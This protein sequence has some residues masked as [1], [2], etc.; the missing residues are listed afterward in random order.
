MN[1]PTRC[2]VL[3]VGGGAAGCIIA[4]RI[5]E[6]TDLRVLLVEAGRS[7][8]GDAAATDLSR[9]DEQDESYDWGF[10]AQTMAGKSTAIDYARAKML[11]G[12][13]NHND[14]AF[15]E[16]TPNDLTQWVVAGAAGWDHGA[17]APYLA[18]VR[19][20]VGIEAAPAG[21]ALSRALIDAA[22]VLGLEERNFRDAIDAGAGWFPLNA[23]GS[24]RQSSSICYLHPLSA[25]PDNLDV[26]TDTTVSALIMEGACV[27]GARTSRGDVAAARE[28]VLTAGSIGSP[29]LMMVSGIGPAD[30][31]LAHGVPVHAALAGVGQNLMDHVAANI[32]YE[33]HEAPAPWDRTPCEATVLMRT[34]P[35]AVDPDVLFHFVLRLREK[36][37]GADQFAGVRHGVKLS[38]NVARP[39]SRGTLTLA[40]PDIAVQPAL[41][42]NYLSDPDGYDRRTLLRGLRFARK[43]AAAEPLASY[44]K[45]EVSPG[46]SIDDDDA[47]FAYVAETCETV[48]HPS[49]TCRMGR[50]DDP[51]AVVTP[52]LRVR[53]CQ[54]LRVADASVFP[55]MV[56][57]NICNTVMMVAERAADL[58]C[59]TYAR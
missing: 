31:L 15:L 7:D 22:L 42:L 37:V 24:L 49:G 1:E 30:Q 52:D 16:P 3:I 2:D 19:E 56:T 17:M 57:V 29:H 32:V 53:G 4:R 55:E 59:A 9:L 33:T 45:R 5:A 41:S 23:R 47:L 12:C 48:Y 46:M 25:L 27:T 54:G 43:L 10:V 58:V 51:L 44:L 34:E 38:P 8:E 18:R 35:H 21:T 50:E 26:W 6:Q 13:A 20:R 36:Y 28:V 14:C 39:K 40:S 11:G